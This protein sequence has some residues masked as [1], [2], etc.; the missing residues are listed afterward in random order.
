MKNF[1]FGLLII[2]CSMILGCDFNFNDVPSTIISYDLGF[3]S[4]CCYTDVIYY[5]KEKN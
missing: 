4:P 5:Y 3:Y 2:G 1:L